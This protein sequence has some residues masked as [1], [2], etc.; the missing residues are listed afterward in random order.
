[1]SS[2]YRD[3]NLQIVF[4]VTLMVVMG[5]S[6]IVPALP[7]IM[8]ALSIPP[9]T[10]GL[11]ITAFTLPGVLIAPL[12][13]ILADRFGRKKVLIPA[14]VCFGVC[15]AGC[16]LTNDLWSLL[17]LRFGQGIGAGPLG[18][19]YG[20]IIGDLYQGRQRTTAMG[21]NASVLSLGTALFPALGGVLSLF[22]WR[23]PFLLSLTAL[24]VAWLCRTRLVI[25]EPKPTGSMGDYLKSALR[26]MRSGPVLALFACTLLGF[27]ILYG[28]L[29][30]YLPVLLHQRFAASPL[31]I[32]T[33]F[34]SASFL[35]AL[36]AF[37]LGWLSAHIRKAVLLLAAAASYFI[38]VVLTP[39]MPGAWW[40]VAP[41]LFFGLAQ[42]LCVP[43]TMTMLAGLAPEGQRAAY[44]AANGTLLR[45]AQ[46]LAPMAMGLVYAASGLDMVFH[47]SAALAVV[48]AVAVLAGLGLN[49]REAA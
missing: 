40:T 29:V 35:T 10:I 47:V 20:T 19:L 9:A 33:V 49:F 38:C 15:G 6:S 5:V 31:V 26:S 48:M 39:R 24:P 7:S 12:T 4:G 44:M 16:A 25:P 14:L 32:G 30:T 28:P 21:V 1:M 18:V 22:G 46:T 27:C 41:V 3:K 23:W 34:G 17:L 45:L 13:G 42:G 11:V 36:A 37:G 2:L 43:T 8:V